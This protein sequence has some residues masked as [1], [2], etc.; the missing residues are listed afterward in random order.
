MFIR[1]NIDFPENFSV[2]LVFLADDARKIT[3]IRCNGPHGEFRTGDPDHPHFGTHVHVAEAGRVNSGARD[4]AG[5]V[6]CEEFA[7]LDDAIAFFMIRCGVANA[8]DYFPRS[9][10][11]SLL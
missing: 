2:G 9:G 4:E 3:L 11:T 8:R 6:P 7:T 5:A 10:Q 1:Q